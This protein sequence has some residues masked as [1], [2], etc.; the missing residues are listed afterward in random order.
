MIPPSELFGILAAICLIPSLYRGAVQDLKEFKFSESHFDSL[1]INAAIVFDVL[2]YISLLIEGSWMLAI[3]W[4]MLSII[5]SLIFLFIAFRYGGG[6]DWR[7]L[8]FI[9][10]IAPF[11]LISV[12]LASAVCGVVQAIYWVART[13]IDTPP[14][15]RKIPFALSIFAGYLISLIWLIA[16]AL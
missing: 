12:I 5:A 7:A 11:M 4:L 2:M 14:M 6:G 8:I 10:W 3:E 1:W 13:D 9:S 15:Y 16:T